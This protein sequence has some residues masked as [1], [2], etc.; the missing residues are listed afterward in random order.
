MHKLTRRTALAS[1]GIAMLAGCGGSNPTPIPTPSPAP[2]PPPTPTPSPT[3]TPLPPIGSFGTLGV[4][5][6][7]SYAVLGHSV[8]GAGTGWDFAPVRSS[9]TL[10]PGISVRFVPPS[11]LVLAIPGYGEGEMVPDEAA[12]GGV[13]QGERAS[14][15]FK[16]LGGVLWVYRVYRGATQPFKYLLEAYFTSAP[17]T[18]RPD[19]YL[20]ATFVYGLSTPVNDLPAVGVSSYIAYAASERALTVDFDARTV[21]GSLDFHN[22]GLRTYQ[23]AD[24]VLSEDRTHF[25]GRLV[26]TDNTPEGQIDGLFMGPTGVEI[27]MRVAFLQQP[28]PVYPHMVYARRS[29]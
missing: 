12:G 28:Q 11:G 27:A 10:D 15:A 7:A 6:A 19:P 17:D 29:S 3:P 21:T 16:A 24:G 14:A 22:N 20:L 13:I 1:V 25:T 2:T 23:L 4:T 18:A 8:R 5:T 26:P 9:L